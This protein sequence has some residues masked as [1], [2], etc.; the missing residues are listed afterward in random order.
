MSARSILLIAAALLLTVG[1]VFVARNWLENRKPGPAPVAEKAVHT[2]VLV[3][4]SDLPTGTFINEQH[5]RWQIWPDDNLPPNYLVKGKVDRAK[6]FG[7]VLRRGVAA[8]QPIIRSQIVKPGDRGF[9]AAVLKPGHRAYTIKISAAS[10]IAG[11]IFPGD[12]IDLILTQKIGKRQQV[13]ETILQNLRILAIDQS[14]NDQT[15]KPRV[16]KTATFEVSPKQAEILAVSSSLG[17]LSL[18]L[19]SLARTDA[20]LADIINTGQALQ[21]ADATRGGTFTR[22]SEASVLRGRSGT[23]VN[24]IRGGK[25]KKEKADK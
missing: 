4:R 3:A 14:I 11:L 20:E 18:S 15:N 1:T 16:G 10:A 9:L 2:E 21:E 19:R 25:T 12:R 5:V 24:V 13:S 23:G 7:S 22:D 8:G 17:K 6:L